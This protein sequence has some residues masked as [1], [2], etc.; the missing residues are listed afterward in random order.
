MLPLCCYKTKN[1]LLLFLEFKIVPTDSV[2]VY[3][4]SGERV[5]CIP[6]RRGKYKYISH[7]GAETQDKRF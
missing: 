7:K 6:L 5:V 1:I 2:F 4:N 3:L